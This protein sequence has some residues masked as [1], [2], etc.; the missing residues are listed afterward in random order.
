MLSKIQ[1]HYFFCAMARICDI[2]NYEPTNSDEC[3]LLLAI[4]VCYKCQH[5][6]SSS[7]C[8]HIRTVCVIS[9]SIK[10]IQY[11]SA[12]PPVSVRKPASEFKI[13]MLLSN[14]G[15]FTTHPE[16]L[17]NYLIPPAKFQDSVLNQDKA[18]SCH[19][20]SN[21]LLSSNNLMLH[22]MIYWQCRQINCK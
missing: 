18:I 9:I 2:V 4:S 3:L 20:L 16:V 12:C 21:K 8:G 15:R 7:V 13:E 19:T 10:L 5:P 1:R 11:L 22:R 6:I 17:R 14:H